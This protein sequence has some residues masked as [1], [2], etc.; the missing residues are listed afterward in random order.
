ME[1]QK[2]L[3]FAQMQRKMFSKMALT[4]KRFSVVAQLSQNSLTPRHLGFLDKF[5]ILFL[6]MISL[7]CYHSAKVT[8]TY[9]S[10]IE[11]F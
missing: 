10:L 6:R 7:R 8:K 2:K 3:A 9:S 4:L 11:S 1:L 5:T